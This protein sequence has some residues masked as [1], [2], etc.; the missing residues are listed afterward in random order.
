[1]EDGE[2]EIYR[3]STAITAA[4][5]YL[6]EK[7][8]E[9]VSGV[10]SYTDTP[11]TGT[12]LF[13]AVFAK[14][15]SQSYKICIPYRNVSTDAVKIA[16]A[17]IEETK[18]TII[19][20]LKIESSETVVNISLQSSNEKREVLIFRSTTPID[21]YKKI[22]GSLKL[23]QTTGSIIEYADSPIAGIGYYYAAVDA[24]LF[25]VGGR[26]LLYEGNY[27]MKPI[28]V[29]FSHDLIDDALYV[30]SKMPLPLLKIRADLESGEILSE[31]KDPL[32]MGSISSYNISLTKRL[33]GTTKDDF[34]EIKA[35]QLYGNEDINEII[36]NYFIS[37]NWEKTISELEP[38][39]SLY[40]RDKTRIE[41]HFYRGQAFYFNKDYYKSMLEFIMIEKDMY[42]ET[43][44]W[45]NALYYRLKQ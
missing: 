12:D 41:S 4:D 2:Y 30:K 22:R 25:G 7:I 27:S 8:G 28:E 9:T 10:E 39:T 26:T 33:I 29:R 20:N 17:N 44:P 45:F 40:T 24:E 37:S 23:T 32:T 21:T 35:V 18:S 14:D 6:A 42:V 5:L 31:K 38:F 36:N 13:Y 34:Q 15:S 11:P 1:M 43:A 3:S 16:E 19:S